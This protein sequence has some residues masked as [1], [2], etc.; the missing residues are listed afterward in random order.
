ML[1]L[2]LGSP[3]QFQLLL[4]LALVAL[5][6]A[7]VPSALVLRPRSLDQIADEPRDGATAR[8]EALTAGRQMMVS[9]RWF[10]IVH[11]IKSMPL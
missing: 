4:R 3:L 8:S 9:A 6:A 5:L 11:H 10:S 7:G 2:L 1:A